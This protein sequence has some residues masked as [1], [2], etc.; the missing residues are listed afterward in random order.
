MLV[1]AAF[2]DIA[3]AAA[4]FGRFAQRL[5]KILQMEDAGVGVRGDKIQGP[6]RRMRAG[7]GLPRPRRCMPSVRLQIQTGKG[8]R[9]GQVLANFAQ[10]LVRCAAPPATGYK[11]SGRPDSKTSRSVLAA[12]L[13]RCCGSMLGARG[14]L[15]Y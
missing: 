4:D 7:L 9:A 14:T 13:S 12:R 1:E 15:H 3:Q 10:T 5:V 8:A 6:A 11:L 2:V